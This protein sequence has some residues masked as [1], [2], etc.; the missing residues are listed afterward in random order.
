MKINEIFLLTGFLAL[1]FTSCNCNKDDDDPAELVSGTG[2]NLTI[3]AFPQHHGKA[4]INHA[5]YPDS[6]YVKFNTQEFPGDGLSYYDT[7]YVGDDV[8]ED[9]VHIEGIKPGKLFIFMAGL[10]TTIGQRVVGGVP[11]NTS[12]SSGELDVYVP[13]TE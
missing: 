13:V 10:D 11:V 6:A 2:G 9:H 1:S 12:Q 7:V 8:G 4:I 3:V 5:N